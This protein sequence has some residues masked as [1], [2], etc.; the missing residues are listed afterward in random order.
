MNGDYCVK[1]DADIYIYKYYTYHF[2]NVTG[3]LT[4]QNNVKN[5][6]QDG[7]I[8]IGGNFYQKTSNAN[9][10]PS[11]TAVQFTGAKVH[12]IYFENSDCY[13]YDVISDEG[14]K[15]KFTNGIHGFTLKRDLTVEGNHELITGTMDLNGYTLTING[16]L[17]QTGG[18]MKLYSGYSTLNVNG[19]YCVKNDADIYIYKYYIYHF[20][21]VTGDLTVQNNVKNT[22]QDGTITIGG[23]FYQKNGKDNDGNIVD[24]NFQS[25]GTAV[26]FKGAGT[27]TISAESYLTTLKSLILSGRCICYIQ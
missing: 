18:R 24:N 25:S 8:T 7:T 21:N 22:L 4:V 16:N 13:M 26:N 3:D 14:A 10:V 17:T 6:L 5:T 20:I 11:G 15:V 12:E 19:D 23:N 27:H 9:F 1:N 2:I